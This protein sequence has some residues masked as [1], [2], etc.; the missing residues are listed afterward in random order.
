MTAGKDNA[1]R[2]AAA[3]DTLKRDQSFA[4][5]RCCGE[6][7]EGNLLPY[8]AMRER[9][10]EMLT[11]M[12]DAIDHFLGDKH[13]DFKQWDRDAHQPAEFIQALRDMGLFG[14]IIPEQFGGLELSNA[15][16]A[17]VLGQ[18]SRHD[19][20]VSRTRGAHRSSGMKGVRR[21]GSTEKNTRQLPKPAT[22]ERIAELGRHAAWARSWRARGRTTRTRRHADR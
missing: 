15:A 10:R 21:M 2:H 22:G 9:D 6:I 4:N 8:P 19:R 11:A 7:L 5:N 18:T 14:L 12:V 16:Y 1:R 13:A 20:S 3:A 17:R